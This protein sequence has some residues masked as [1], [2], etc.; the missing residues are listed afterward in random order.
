MI[1]P[2]KGREVDYSRPV[3]AYRNLHQD[4]WSIQQRGLVVAHAD[5]AVITQAK[6]VVREG[7]RQKVVASGRKNVHAGV[8]G[9]LGE[10]WPWTK[11]RVSYNPF[12]AGHFYHVASGEPIHKASSVHLDTQGKAWAE[13]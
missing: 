5:D 6:F 3:F 11:S 2:F 9:Y 1:K 8:V 13:I 12:K 4:L 10:C 7:G